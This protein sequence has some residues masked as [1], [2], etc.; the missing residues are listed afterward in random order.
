MEE[1][2]HYPAYFSRLSPEEVTC[3][4]FGI[5]SMEECN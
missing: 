2:Q 3:S 4:I 1:E 5:L